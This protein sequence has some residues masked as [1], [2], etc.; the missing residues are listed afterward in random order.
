MRRGRKKI[1]FRYLWF[2]LALHILNISIDT[3]DAKP[4]SVPEDLSFNDIES[5]AELVLEN[6]LGIKDAVPEHD[7]S[8]HEEGYSQVLK[9]IDFFS[10]QFTVKLPLTYSLP[11]SKRFPDHA[12]PFYAP[13][14]LQVFSPPPDA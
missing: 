14:H 6:W 8:D 11:L 4:A 3:P 13:G 9:K 7:E 12:L 1:W 10:Q 2:V 5:V